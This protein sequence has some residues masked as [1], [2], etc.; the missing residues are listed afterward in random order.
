MIFEYSSNM[1]I[2]GVFD[3]Y[4]FRVILGSLGALVSKWPGAQKLAVEQKGVKF[5]TRLKWP[6]T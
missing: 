6:V 1:Y 5:G 4:V 3:L 2:C